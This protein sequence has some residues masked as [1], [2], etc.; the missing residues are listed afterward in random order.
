[1]ENPLTLLSLLLFAFAPDVPTPA[2]MPVVPANSWET[3]VIVMPAILAFLTS[4]WAAWLS[5]NNAAKISD[6]HIT[7]NSRLSQ[8]LALTESAA[9]AEGKLAGAAEARLSM[10]PPPPSTPANQ[11]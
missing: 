9:R 7:V 10:D 11:H 3:L 6:L 5:H 4:A 1:M 2:P 8:L